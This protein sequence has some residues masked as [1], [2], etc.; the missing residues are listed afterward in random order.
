L[1]WKEISQDLEKKYPMYRLLCGDV[2]FGKTE[3]ALRSAFRVVSNGRQALLMAPTSVLASQH[4]R[5]CVDRMRGVAVNVALLTRFNT[6]KEKIKIKNSW[7]QGKIDILIGT[8]SV[9]YDSIFIKHTSLFIIDE[10]HRFGVKDK[11]GFLE[12]FVNKDVLLMSATPIPRSLNAS[13]SGLS[14]ISTLGTPPVLR[15][16]IQTFVNYFDDVLIKRSIDFELSRSGQIFFVHNNISSILSIKSYLERLCPY[17]RVLVAHSKVGS[18][19]LKEHLFLFVNKKVDM[20]LCTSIIGSGIDIPNANTIIVNSAHRFGLGQLHQIRGRVGRSNRQGY[21]Y[22]LVP[23]ETRLTP[24][25][26]KRLKTIE[27]NVSLGSGYHIAKSDLKIRGGGLMFGYKQSGRRYDFGFEFYSKLVSRSLRDF[28]GLSNNFFV[29]NFVYSVGFLCCFPKKYI[30]S[31]FDRLRFYRVLNGLYTKNKVLGF[32]R[33][34]VNRFGALPAPAVNLI[35]MRLVVILASKLKITLLASRSNKLKFVFNNTFKQSVGLF[36]FLKGRVCVFGVN[37]HSFEVL[38][39][40]TSL[41][42]EL[43]EGCPVV[44]SLILSLLEELYVVCEKG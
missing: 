33:D 26:K 22:L 36:K 30:E 13:F 24:S 4:F 9:L 1:V 34:L 38:E 6:A 31:E 16:P 5:V 25:S 8:H 44:A 29:D 28:S 17:L 3:L 40:A 39:N 19:T 12:G 20:L 41:S 15:R 14:D 43:D 7:I 11:E 2:G 18:K 10:E 37:K 23:K 21:A 27:Q 42:F 32:K 35:N